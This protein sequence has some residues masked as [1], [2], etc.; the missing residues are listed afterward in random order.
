M[1]D[2]NSALPEPAVAAR[3]AGL[4]YV[5]KD[6]LTIHRAGANGTFRYMDAKGRPVKKARALA[7]IRALAIPPA[8]T[9]V[10]ISASEN[11]HLQAVGIDVRGRRQYRYHPR[12][13]E[14]RDSSKYEHVLAFARML[15]RIRRRVA[16]D[17]GRHA[18]SREKVL[19]TIV[20]LLE[21][22]LIR[23]GNEEYVRSN[24]SFGL[25]TMRDRHVAVRGATMRF[26]FRGKAGKN[27]SIRVTDRRLAGVIRRLQ[28]LPGQRL[29]QFEAE[30]GVRDVESGDVNAYLREITGA[31]FTAKDFRTW[32]GTVLAAASLREMEKFDSEAQAKRNILAAIEQTAAQLGNTA[33]ICRKCYI[34]PEVFDAYLDGTLALVAEERA[35]EKIRSLAALR[36]E[37]AAVL[38]LLQ[39]RLRSAAKKS[40]HA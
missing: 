18:L 34:H 15:P 33:A 3:E 2:E 4:T 35:R 11:G 5:S 9:D 31:D 16:R 19:A 12:W 17:L 14:V 30:D 36:P 20:S 24:G 38:A 26:R 29:F 25:S 7:R 13:R 40:R 37:E 39:R 6:D 23:V 21:S 1:K 10:R 22:T 27:H 8:W 28:E 32:A